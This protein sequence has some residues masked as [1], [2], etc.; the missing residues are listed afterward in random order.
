MPEP[1]KWMVVYT[2]YSSPEAY[3][4]AGRLE[5]EGIHAWVHQEPFGSAMGFT[6]GPLGEVK[7]VVYLDDYERALSILSVDERD[8]LPE[9]VDQIIF[10][11]DEA[12][13]FSDKDDEFLHD[14]DT[15]DE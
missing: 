12:E 1:V 3:I 7:V 2:T 15:D 6:I 10:D 14:S 11:S 5:S 9:D 4:I 13:A 8:A